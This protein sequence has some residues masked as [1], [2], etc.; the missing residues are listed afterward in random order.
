MSDPAV[1]SV[2]SGARPPARIGHMEQLDVNALVPWVHDAGP[3]WAGEAEPGV[4]CE[5]CECWRIKILE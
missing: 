1:G 4:V 3:N 5:L 2:C